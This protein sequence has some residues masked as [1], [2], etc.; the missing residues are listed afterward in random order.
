MNH[1]MVITGVDLDEKGK[2]LKWKIQNSW[3]DEHGEKGY[4]L[5]G[6]EWFDHFV[7]QAVIHKKYLTEAQI[8]EANCGADPSQS[9]GSNGNTG[10]IKQQDEINKKFLWRRKTDPAL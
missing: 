2:A 4:Y 7:Y 3:S 10:K 1:A 8:A 6:A 9:M 5:M